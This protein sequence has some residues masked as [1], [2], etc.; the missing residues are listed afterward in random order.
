MPPSS[1]TMYRTPIRNSARVEARRERL[2]ESVVEAPVLQDRLRDPGEDRQ[3][4]A[5]HRASLS[6]SAVEV[7][8]ALELL[9][10][11]PL[12]LLLQRGGGL[13]GRQGQ[14]L[15]QPGAGGLHDLA[16]LRGPDHE[17]VGPRAAGQ[18]T[19][20]ILDVAR[21]HEDQ[22]QRR[23][24]F[25]PPQGDGQLEPVQARH[26]HVGDHDVRGES[27][28]EMQ[29]LLA[30]DRLEHIEAELRHPQAQQLELQGIVV[31]DEHR[32]AVAESVG[33]PQ[34][35]GQVA[36]YDRHEPVGLDR[37]ADHVVESRRGEA[38]LVD[39]GQK[40]GERNDR[41]ILFRRGGPEVVHQREPAGIGE[42]QVE[43]HE[44]WPMFLH[45]REGCRTIGGV[46]H[47]VPALREGE[48][49]HLP[50]GRVVLHKEDFAL[51]HALPSGW[52]LVGTRRHRQDPPESLLVMMG[53]VS[54]ESTGPRRGTTAKKTLPRPTELSTPTDPP[55][56]STIFRV[57]ARPSPVPW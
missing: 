36:F 51:G 19:I 20:G 15:A 17:V 9:D 6:E 48:R 34:V 52:N 50:R 45:Q 21:G 39:L 2:V 37:L 1:R 53:W 24:R 55:W 54:T 47:G 7:Y 27:A 30:V 31:G 11:P 18:F 25:A 42:H 8:L 3:L 40:A 41:G 13:D 29:R 23:E 14:G 46:D 10:H 16:E 28:C 44:R 12:S 22:G 49:N 56:A 33:L 26:H 57:S 35:P 4:G 38:G 5:Q 32:L 43:E